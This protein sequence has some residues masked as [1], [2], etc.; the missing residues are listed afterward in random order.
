[1]DRDNSVTKV[2]SGYIQLATAGRG[3]AGVV[4]YCLPRSSVRSLHAPET[5]LLPPKHSV[6]KELRTQLVA[7]KIGHSKLFKEVTSREVN[8]L[9]RLKGFNAYGKEGG[10]FAQ[11]LDY[12]I[13]DDSLGHCSWLAVEAIYPSIQLEMLLYG[14]G[15]SF[16]R[17]FTAH[18]FLQLGEALRFLHKEL[19][20][21]HG[22][23]QYNN[24]LVDL[25]SRHASGFFNLVVHDFSMSRELTVDEEVAINN[26]DYQLPY[27]DMFAFYSKTFDIMDDGWLKVNPVGDNIERAILFGSTLTCND[28]NEIWKRYE[29]AARALRDTREEHVV[30]SVE[31]VA[32]KALAE[33]GRDCIT[34]EMLLGAL[35]NNGIDAKNNLNETEE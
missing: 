8:V 15:R 12:E 6:A 20:V 24:L 3:S 18:L 14:H 2:P 7:V 28:I 30:E 26:H 11:L 31:R 25:S 27:S 4:F 34:D 33:S 19:Q 32:L 35:S 22:D 13:V 5:T 16:P 29:S 1:M 10:R 9:Q 17:E 21:T 23:F